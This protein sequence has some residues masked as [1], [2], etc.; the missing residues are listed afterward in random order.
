MSSIRTLVVFTCLLAAGR[1]SAETP[2]ASVRYHVAN[3]FQVGGS[4]SWDYL[5]VDAEHQRLFVP[6]T[7]H[8][9]VLDAR[10]GRTLADIPGQKRNHGVA[11]VPAVGRGFISD[12]EDASVFIF[13][14]KTYRVL[15]KVKAQPD[16]DGIIF[17]P[18]TKKVLVVSGDGG[19]LIPI[20]PE[21]DP[22]TGSADP[23][24][25]LGGSPEF[26]AADGHGRAYVNLMD[27]N[28]VAVVDLAARKVIAHWPTAPGGAPVGMAMDREHRRLFIGCRNPQKLIV[29]NADDGAIIAN[30]PI[31]AGVD[32]VQFDAGSALASCGD[33]TLTVLGET[34]PGKFAIVQTVATHAGARTAGLDPLTHTLYLPTAEFAPAEPGRRPKALPD[35]FIVLAVSRAP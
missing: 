22:S 30:V 27:K 2:A 20:S 17:D 18:A 19:V 23:A 16:A 32:A 31:G 12:G 13:D 5:T 29:M 11:L 3:T 21:V 26:L 34:V 8:T 1:I 33:G 10:T 7:T 15:G 4:G 14:L 25:E 6:R 35:T 28:Q 9:L 24:I